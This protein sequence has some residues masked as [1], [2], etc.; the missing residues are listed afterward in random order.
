M[1]NFVFQNPTKIIFGK[2][3]INQIAGEI[4]KEAKVLITYGGGSALRNGVIAEVKT[5]LSGHYLT[6]F[7]GI[8]PNP[9]YETI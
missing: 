9:E 4:P 3:S 5:A 8:E 6:E 1:L 2:G 7:G